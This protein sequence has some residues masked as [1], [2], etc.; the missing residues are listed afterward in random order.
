M[1]EILLQ[2]KI[3]EII[4]LDNNNSVFFDFI[5][6]DDKLSCTNKYSLITKTYNPKYNILFKLYE[7]NIACNNNL[8][9]NK[10]YK[11]ELQIKLLEQTLLYI[12]NINKEKTLY[13][14]IWSKNTIA[15]IENISFFYGSDIKD[16]IDKFYYYNDI[17]DYTI[18]SL[19]LEK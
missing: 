15:E 14:I 1:E 12:Q 2:C 8:L 4:K 10:K 19:Q 13:K 9:Y 17:F 5:T 18:L 16:V 3:M 7:T 11:T 6:N